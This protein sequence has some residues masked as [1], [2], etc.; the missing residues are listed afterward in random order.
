MAGL[1]KGK[2][3]VLC[4]NPSFDINGDFRLAFLKDKFDNVE[5][6]QIYSYA[7][8]S[9]DDSSRNGHLNAKW[10]KKLYERLQATA[11]IFDYVID[12]D[13][14]V[15]GPLLQAAGE[16]NIPTIG[17]PPGLPVFSDGYFPDTD[18]FKKEV[19][20]ELNYNIVP[21]QIDADYRV[22][23]GFRPDRVRVLGSA[24]F[25][26][27]W[28]DIINTIVPP[29]KLPEDEA[30]NK[31]KVV[32]MERGA[33]LH[34]R[35]KKVIGESIAKMSLLD[36]MHLIIKPHTRARTLH[37]SD[38]CGCSNIAGEANSINLIK[39]A[40][41]VIGTNSSILI[42]A[43]MQDK[44]LLYPKYFHDDEMIFNEMGTCWSVHS[45]EELENVLREIHSG[46]FE[47]PYSRENVD[48]LF[49]KIVYGGRNNRDVLDDYVRFIRKVESKKTIAI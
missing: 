30:E 15:T 32:Y 29:D 14:F 37:F 3:F 13:Q 49:E 34:G 44:I 35:Y 23:H 2:I 16:M 40:D 4:Q 48:A 26:K 5:I 33:D 18:L 46:N 17:V 39:W 24:R 11:L 20:T 22:K 42:E 43:L 47:R 36:C 38:T 28:R 27:E 25:C 19:R 1:D 12:S 7:G 21:H 6:E 31:L 41:V 45:S 9:N 8:Y 10:A